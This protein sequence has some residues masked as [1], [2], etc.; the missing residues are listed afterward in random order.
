MDYI[1]AIAD[2]SPEQGLVR[3]DAD[4]SMSPGSYEAALRC[5]GGGVLAVDEVMAGKAANAFVAVRP[6]GHHAETARPMGFCLFN[7][8]AIVTRYAQ[9]KHGAERAALVDFDVHHG[10]GSQ[11]IF[12]SDRSVLYCSTHEMPLYPGTG[13]ITERGESNTI[14]NAPLRAGDGGDQFREA[15]ETAILPRLREFKPDVLVISAGFDAHTRDPL[16]NLNLVEADFT[17]VTQKLMEVADAMLRRPHRLDARRRLRSAGPVALGRGARHR[18]D[19]GVGVSTHAGGLPLPSGERVGVRGF[20]TLGR[21]NPSPAALRASTSPYGRGE[22]SVRHAPPR[23]R[24]V[25]PPST[26]T[27]APVMK[28]AASDNRNTQA[29]ATSSG[30]PRRPS[31]ISKASFCLTASGFLRAAGDLV[32]HRPG[33]EGRAQRIGAHRRL[34]ARAVQRHRLGQQRHAALGGVVRG[35]VRAADEAEHRRH[36]DDRAAL[37]CAAAGTRICSRGKCRRD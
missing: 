21:C 26:G 30:W 10:N 7:S 32:D 15:F 33:D 23:Y 35:E 20:L 37:L 22:E 28:P 25:R 18:A 36:I 6:P 29:D 4:T 31:G 24:A 12:W 17:W 1:E 11:D 14:V 9:K 13:A 2:A 16:A 34:V 3:L 19:A 5:V 8:A 27:S